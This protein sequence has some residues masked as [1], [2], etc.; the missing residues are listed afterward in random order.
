[1]TKCNFPTP[2]DLSIPIPGFGTFSIPSPP[3]LPSFDLDLLIDIPS[4]PDLS[5]P[6]PSFSLP[7][8][9]GLPSGFINP[10]CPLD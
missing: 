9:P 7:S 10:S 1:M 4:P 5:I 2:P 3:G 6:T 8:L